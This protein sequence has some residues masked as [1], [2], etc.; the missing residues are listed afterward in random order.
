M[1]AL[2]RREL[3]L[4]GLASAAGLSNAGEA[5]VAD[6]HQYI[7]DLARQ[8]E[9]ERRTRFRSVKTKED[10]LALQDSLRQSFLQLIGG[11][12]ERPG[13]PAVTKTGQIEAEDYRVEKLAFESF[14]GYFVS[15]LL[16]VPKKF[17][18]PMPGVLSP[19]GHSTNGKAATTYQILHVN[20]AKRGFVL[21]TYDP[22][23]QGERSQFWDTERTKSRFDLGCGE[24]AVLGNAL[25]LLG[26]SLAR[27]RIWD[28]M[29][30]IDYLAS[31]PEVNASKIG[32][33]GNSGGGTLT[34]YISALD[35]RV[36]AAAIC[37]YITTLPRR[38]ANR[39]QQDPS[40]DP[41]QDISGFVS[42][43]I[44]H[45][46]LL[47]LRA[48]SP[49]LVGSATLDFFPIEGARESFAEAKR[50]FEVAGAGE[51]VSMVESPTR[52][53]LSQ[54]LREA[55]YGWFGRWL[56]E[57]EDPEVAREITV[58]PRPD[59][60]L[61]VCK[62]GQV[63]QS[64]QSRPLLPLALEEFCKAQ[65]PRRKTLREVLKLNVDQADPLVNEVDG[66][67]GAGEHL[68]IC[69]NGNDAPDWREAESL[70]GS[71]KRAGHAVAIVDPRGVGRRRANLSAGGHNYTDPI[72]SVEANI[73]YNAFLVGRSLLGLRVAD[74]L[75]AVQLMKRQ[76][77]P[78]KLTL[79]GRHDAAIVACLAAAADESIDGVAAEELLLSYL[80][81][82][83]AE[84]FPFN[85]AS[86]LPGLLRDF[87]DIS[88]LL[89]AI[90][91]RKIL[92][93]A[94]V[95]ALPQQARISAL[96]SKTRFS[97]NSNVLTDWL[98]S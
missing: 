61:L 39:I 92:I 35:K 46:G 29:R 58:Q 43:G 79:C 42:E 74:V 44:D 82:F 47:A 33:V 77:K 73:A 66:V 5:G 17:T 78:G 89:R 67:S 65:N 55:V 69:I 25:E 96:V 56:M 38:M 54:P 45:A 28:G 31:L 53:G 11:L 81:L 23:G 80:T 60:E 72:S 36:T 90:S 24:H 85:A 93:A 50:L 51:S 2:S 15:A 19:C 84:G 95:G 98:K 52:H 75:A 76:R 18:G 22:V 32:C 9:N 16:Y 6:L 14:P 68:V 62:A 10:L 91:P 87:G 97:A 20:L 34:A 1:G 41:E 26:M 59:A 3:I 13:V 94:G 40:S 86:V 57:R 83:S 27:Y 48:P 88:E 8:F 7:L 37:C 64:F 12:P 49:T 21:L 70:L 30:G 63:N 71:L 4:L